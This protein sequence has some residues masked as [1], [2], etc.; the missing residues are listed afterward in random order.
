MEK[1]VPDRTLS[2][3]KGGITPLGKYKNSLVFWQIEAICKRHGA[4]IKTPIKN[5]PPEAMDDI[6]NGTE[7]PVR[8]QNMSLGNSNYFFSYEG[9]AKYIDML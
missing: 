1:I 4:T 6:I 3:Y 8:I 7:E 2:I 5:L 9:L